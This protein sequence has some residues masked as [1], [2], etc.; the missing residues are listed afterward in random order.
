MDDDPGHADQQQRQQQRPLNPPGA[1]TGI[2]ALI[3]RPHTAHRIHPDSEPEPSQEPEPE[4]QQHNNG[5][6]FST[7]PEPLSAAATTAPDPDAD[8]TTTETQPAASTL[9]SLLRAG[10][11]R[12]PSS[13]RAPIDDS[14]HLHSAPGP[15]P[16]P[17]RLSVPF[18][19]PRPIVIQTTPAQPS[20]PAPIRQSHHRRRNE[21][22]AV[23]CHRDCWKVRHPIP[24]SLFLLPSTSI[25]PK[26]I[27]PSIHQSTINNQTCCP[28]LH[29][30]HTRHLCRASLSSSGTLRLRPC[31]LL[32][33]ADPTLSRST[34]STRAFLF[35][36]IANTPYRPLAFGLSTIRSIGSNTPHTP[37]RVHSPLDCPPSDLLRLTPS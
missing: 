25:S 6:I 17:R 22:L 18:A 32:A 26:S 14:D 34:R 11:S 16:T 9:R 8:P 27:N 24:I 4:P 1:T 30:R 15:L 7:S 10:L 2:S 35:R 29:I 20:A 19:L 31:V 5:M 3:P 12:L 33:L 36:L 23:L 37:P 28:H 21:R 13:R